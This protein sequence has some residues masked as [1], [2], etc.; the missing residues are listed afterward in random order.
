MIC[1]Q[2]IIKMMRMMKV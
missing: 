2:S 1:N